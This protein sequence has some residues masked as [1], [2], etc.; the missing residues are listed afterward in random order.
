MLLTDGGAGNA[1]CLFCPRKRRD[2]A[3]IAFS[4]P[5]VPT[6]INRLLRLHWTVRAREQKRWRELVSIA[7]LRLPKAQRVC[8]DKA[9]VTLTFISPRPSDPD[10][11]AK[12]VLD[13]LVRAAFLV[14]DGPP[15]LVELRLRS[16]PGKSPQPLVRIAGPA[17]IVSALF[18][19][20]VGRSKP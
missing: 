8:V 7:R 9:T 15:H 20:P 18:P 3:V 14:D 17:S 19:P 16:Q 4:L 11:R 13:A 5:A 6:P 2:A 10:A 1:G 12:C